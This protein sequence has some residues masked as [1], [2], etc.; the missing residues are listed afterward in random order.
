MSVMPIKIDVAMLE[1]RRRRSSETAFAARVAVAIVSTVA[2]MLCAAMTVHGFVVVVE[3]PQHVHHQR[4]ASRSVTVLPK[5]RTRLFRKQ[6]YHTEDR[7]QH[8][9]TFRMSKGR[10]DDE[11][12]RD[13]SS[14]SVSIET[15]KDETTEQQGKQVAVIGSA[16]TDD[17]ESEVLTESERKELVDAVFKGKSASNGNSN[18]SNS[19]Q[20]A[21]VEKNC[22]ENQKFDDDEP[23]LLGKIDGFLDNQFFDPDAYDEDDD[24]FFGKIA[25]FVKA[26]YELFEAVFVACFFLLLITVA[27]DLL[28]AQ[29]ASSGAAASGK[30]F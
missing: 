30:L 13:S 9:F 27:Q 17:S 10:I 21:V 20:P 16:Q 1:R 22:L 25:N 2:L 11:A 24:S 19:Q 7:K 12:E 5:T 6:L 8:Y 3:Q 23:L 18:T 15:N 28:R 26:D 4:T 14:S 29:M